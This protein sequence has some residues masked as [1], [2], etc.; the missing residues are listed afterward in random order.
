MKLTAHG[1]D[2]MSLIPKHKTGDCSRCNAVNVPCKKRG[3]NL[4]CLKCCDSDD[5]KA[6][7]NKAEKKQMVSK[8][9]TLSNEN[10]DSAYKPVGDD[11]L[12]DNKGAKDFKKLIEKKQWFENR[13]AEMTGQCL[14]C[15]G[16]SEKDNDTSF[17]HSIAH[18]LPKKE[19]F[20]GFPSVATHPDN[21]IELCYYGNSCHS[22]FDNSI[23]TWEY[24]K[25][26]SAWPVIVEKFK[27]VYPFIVEKEKRNIPDLLLQEL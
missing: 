16:K 18:L 12:I 3:K 13:R 21:W 11:K 20:G 1:T 17:R 6:Q 27:K 8:V 14:F 10:S 9:R 24:L 26:T 4:L 22:N 2:F 25:E 19:G 15:N 7:V 23:I 5:R